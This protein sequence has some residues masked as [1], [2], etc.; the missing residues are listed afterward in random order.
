METC[1]RKHQRW[2][3]NVLTRLIECV[4][5]EMYSMLASSIKFTK[6][7]HLIDSSD[8]FWHYT[9]IPMQLTVCA[10]RDIDVSSAKYS[11]MHACIWA[12]H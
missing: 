4:N 2:I 10:D 11:M 1:V 5:I 6:Y 12:Y 9:K 8:I 3:L 7:V